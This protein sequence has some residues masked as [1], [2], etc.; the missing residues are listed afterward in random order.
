M[1]YFSILIS[2][3]KYGLAQLLEYRV[4]FLIYSLLSVFWTFFFI[5]SAGLILGNVSS[6]AGWSKNEVLLLTATATL[7]SSLLWFFV[8]PSLN[9]FSELVR[10]GNLDYSLV[11]PINSRLLISIQRF[12][13]NPIVRITLITLFILNLVGSMTLHIGIMQVILYVLMLVLGMIIF[14]NVFYSVTILN[15][16]FTNIFNLEDFFHSILETGR[17]PLDIYKSVF[18]LIFSFII[19]V[20][21]IGTFPVQALLGKLAPEK[22]IFA[23]FLVVATTIFSHYFWNFAL[24]H[25]TSASS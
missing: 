13:F 9:E 4:N 2:F 8:F 12:D 15:I 22:F 18:S 1:R 24:R 3:V 17:Y 6:I 19:P 25:Y 10:K 14:Y 7:F 21:F 20:G 11:K 23:I 5:F 16:W